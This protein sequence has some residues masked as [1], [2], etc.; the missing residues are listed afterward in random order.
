MFHAKERTVF[1]K[2]ALFVGRITEAKGVQQVIE[3]AKLTP[4]WNF[5]IIGDGPDL[6]QMKSIGKGVENLEFVGAVENNA[7]PEYYR[8]QAHLFFPPTGGYAGL[9]FGG[10]CMWSANHHYR[11]LAKSLR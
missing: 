6:N 5:K 1:S 8:K 11:C 2:N 10:S 7:L 4:D 3:A 9:D